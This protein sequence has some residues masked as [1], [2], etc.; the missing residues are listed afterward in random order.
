VTSQR[1]LH[2]TNPDALVWGRS[3][4]IALMRVSLPSVVCLRCTRPFTNSIVEP[5][6]VVSH[7]RSST[8][9]RRAPSR[10][11]PSSML[12]AIQTSGARFFLECEARILALRYPSNAPPQRC[13]MRR[14]FCWGRGSP[15]RVFS[16]LG[17]KLTQRRPGVIRGLRG[18]AR[19]TRRICPCRRFRD[20]RWRRESCPPGS[21][22][23]A[24][25]PAR[26][27]DGRRP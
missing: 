15:I 9:I 21:R 1:R 19:R 12:L 5:W 11:T 2:G 22:R 17:A 18:V 7:M 6:Y 16:L 24:R 27:R 8:S 25:T 23:P 20:R 4:W 26:A 3:F 14:S 13:W 10:C